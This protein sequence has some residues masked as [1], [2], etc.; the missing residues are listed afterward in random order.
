MLTSKQSAGREPR[1][2]SWK[3]GPPGRWRPGRQAS[4]DGPGPQTPPSP[5]HD[6]TGGGT[7]RPTRP[8]ATHDGAGSTC[9]PV[10]VRAAL[11]LPGPDFQMRRDLLISS[12]CVS[13]L[14]VEKG[15]SPL[16]VARKRGPTY[17]NPELCLER[18]RRL[19]TVPTAAVR[20]RAAKSVSRDLTVAT[21]TCSCLAGLRGLGAGLRK[22]GPLTC[23]P[24]L[25]NP[26]STFRCPGVLAISLSPLF[27][28]WLT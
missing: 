4:G 2:G 17:K 7:L 25:S 18:G 27:C 24:F 8:A 3:M 11:A 6:P 10:P 21:V 26:I 16:R 14:T 23:H 9:A 28:I 22:V 5:S 15:S 19:R 20:R 12:S 1:P 13:S